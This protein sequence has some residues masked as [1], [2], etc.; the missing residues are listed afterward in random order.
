MNKGAD[1]EAIDLGGG[2]AL[3]HAIE[4]GHI[5]VVTELIKRGADI[6]V[7]NAKQYSA[8]MIAAK[9]GN[10]NILKQLL[11]NVDLCELDLEQKNSASLNAL[12]M[13]NSSLNS[14]SNHWLTSW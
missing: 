8:L 3:M 2:N 6:D 7:S 10:L 4:G 9:N 12:M 1:I 5:K 14:L 11:S 13:Q